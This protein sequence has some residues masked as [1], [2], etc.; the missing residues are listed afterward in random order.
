MKV[1]SGKSLQNVIDVWHVRAAIEAEGPVEQ[2]CSRYLHPD[3][4]AHAARFRVPSARHQHIV[5]RGMARVVLAGND[6]APETIRFR[7]LDQGKPVVAAPRALRRPFNI[8]HTSGLVICGVAGTNGCSPDAPTESTGDRAEPAEEATTAGASTEPWLGVDVESLQ[9][10]PDLGLARRY[11]APEEIAQIERSR[12]ADA[13]Q[14]FLQI[15]TLKEAFI[16]AIGTGLRTPLDAFAFVDVEG[17]RPELTFHDPALA[18]GRRWYCE[19]FQPRPGF[20]AAIAW[21]T[22]TI[23]EATGRRDASMPL[24]RLHDFQ[25][26]V[27]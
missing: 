9:R 18:R 17:G 8:A 7:Q 14:L 22:P 23:H 15:W 25:S 13:H 6:H 11:F 16:K 10:R 19:S 1:G 21:G 4:T 20:V 24:V 12:E 27:G 3:E 26:W 5:G 2:F